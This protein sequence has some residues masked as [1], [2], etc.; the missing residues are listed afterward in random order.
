MSFY[1]GSGI[2]DSGGCPCLGG[3]WLVAVGVI[4]QTRMPVAGVDGLDSCG[5]MREPD[6]IGC[7]GK[8]LDVCLG[9]KRGD[10]EVRVLSSM[11]C[12]NWI[13]LLRVA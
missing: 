13:V 11:G 3:C 4:L 9:G 2:S 1:G 12:V 10:L 6:L 7:C 8:V 5:C